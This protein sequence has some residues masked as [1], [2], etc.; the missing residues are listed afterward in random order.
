MDQ[1]ISGSGGFIIKPIIRSHC[2]YVDQRC[3]KSE[4][5]LLYYWT[6]LFLPSLIA[7]LK[8]EKHNYF[9]WAENY[10]PKKNYERK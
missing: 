5:F 7:R 1:N 8:A 9:F 3:K 10:I 2:L 4:H 6:D